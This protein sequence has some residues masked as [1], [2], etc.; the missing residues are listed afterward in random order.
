MKTVFAILIGLIVFIGSCSGAVVQHIETKYPNCRIE[1][2]SSTSGGTRVL[3]TCPH[4][5]PFVEVYRNNK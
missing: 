1:E 3:I 5:E 4:K 2:I